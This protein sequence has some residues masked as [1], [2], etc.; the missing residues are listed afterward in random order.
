MWGLNFVRASLANIFNKCYKKAIFMKSNWIWVYIKYELDGVGYF[1]IYERGC[2]YILSHRPNF[3]NSAP[4]SIKWPLPY[5]KLKCTVYDLPYWAASPAYRHLC[6]QWRFS[7][8]C[9]SPLVWSRVQCLTC[10]RVKLT[11][12]SILLMYIQ[13]PMIYQQ[14]L[15]VDF[16]IWATRLCP[17]LL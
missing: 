5:C 1:H 4:A 2:N 15:L 17:S 8:T 16:D 9:R 10:M 14:L 6:L 12:Q 11:I 13:E 3:P 7:S